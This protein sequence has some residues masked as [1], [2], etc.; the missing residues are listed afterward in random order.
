MQKHILFLLAI[1]ITCCIPI[2]LNAECIQGNCKNGK[3]VETYEDGEKY[4]GEKA[5]I[6][7]RQL[8]CM[9]IR[10]FRTVMKGSYY[11]YF[12]KESIYV[13]GCLKRACIDR[14]IQIP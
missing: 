2:C 10:H 11:G 9:G 6:R 1:I 12:R 7:G 8:Q 14:Q 13:F 5:G 4:E 3:G